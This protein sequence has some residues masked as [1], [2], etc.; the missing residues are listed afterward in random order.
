MSAHKRESVAIF[1]GNGTEF[2][3]KVL[4]GA[5]DELGIQKLISNSYHPK[6]FQE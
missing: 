6:V 3:N 1:S 4:K 2:K 5:C